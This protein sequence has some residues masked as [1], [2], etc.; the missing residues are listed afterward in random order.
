MLASS[1]IQARFYKDC[2]GYWLTQNTTIPQFHIYICHV[3][4][5]PR[6]QRWIPSCLEDLH[7]MHLWNYTQ[8]DHLFHLP[9]HLYSH[10]DIV[11]SRNPNISI[12][13]LDIDPRHSC[14]HLERT[15]LSKFSVNYLALYDIVIETIYSYII[16]QISFYKKLNQIE[17]CLVVPQMYQI[18]G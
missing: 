17:D 13:F 8:L 16:F 9:V 18:I 10:A 3:S 12:Q 14:H 2:G 15:H 11:E 5:K 4:T 7:C 6:P 1:I